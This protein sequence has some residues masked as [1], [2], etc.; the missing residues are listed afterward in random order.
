MKQQVELRIVQQC[1]RQCAHL[2]KAAAKPDVQRT[3]LD[4]TLSSCLAVSRCDHAVEASSDA[5]AFGFIHGVAVKQSVEELSPSARVCRV[6][7]AESL[8]PECPPGDAA[9]SVRHLLHAMSPSAQ[10]RH[11]ELLARVMGQQAGAVC[12]SAHLQ[13]TALSNRERVASRQQAL[14]SETGDIRRHSGV[15]DRAHQGRDLFATKR[16]DALLKPLGRYQ[17]VAGEAVRFGLGL[18]AVG[19]VAGIEWA[20]AARIAQKRITDVPWEQDMTELV[21]EREPPPDVHLA[22][23]QQD[24]RSRTR[25]VEV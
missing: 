19:F 10:A 9:R 22:A 17:Q 20:N 6:N 25:T 5:P 13:R 14:Q 3:S 21:C 7:G 18:R 4:S 8:A 11:V 15:L 23:L 12:L 1:A 24:E 16:C 2:G